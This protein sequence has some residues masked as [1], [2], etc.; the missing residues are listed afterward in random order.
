MTY[1][2]LLLCAKSF[3]WRNFSAGALSAETTVQ[4]FLIESA[5]DFVLFFSLEEAA[6]SKSSVDTS[7][8]YVQPSPRWVY[9]QPMKVNRELCYITTPAKKN[10]SMNRN[11]VIAK[12][13]THTAVRKD[14]DDD[15]RGCKSAA[16]PEKKQKNKFHFVPASPPLSAVA[17]TSGRFRHAKKYSNGSPKLFVLAK[18]D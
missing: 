8:T 14:D 10:S 1:T 12:T 9:S 17:P 5:K 11:L 15:I 7:I 13:H 16:Q 6:K 18:E 3:R 2:I 4:F